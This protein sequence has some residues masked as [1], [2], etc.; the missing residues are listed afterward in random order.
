MQEKPFKVV[1][2][3]GE[4]WWAIEE[5]DNWFL[6]ILNPFFHQWGGCPPHW[7]LN[8]PFW[9]RKEKNENCHKRD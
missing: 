9:S 3:S 1:H 5:N 4:E 6:S 8:K 2:P 7:E